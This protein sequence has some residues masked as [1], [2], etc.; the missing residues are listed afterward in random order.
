MLTNEEKDDII[1]FIKIAESERWYHTNRPGCHPS[2][3]PSHSFFYNYPDKFVR[4]DLHREK[5][6][7]CFIYVKPRTR[8]ACHTD[9]YLVSKEDGKSWVYDSKWERII[10]RKSSSNNHPF[11][12][13]W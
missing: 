3:S 4:G 8:F 6:N 7:E 2:F 13:L 1:C 11:Y 12:Q 5:P 10:K 9:V